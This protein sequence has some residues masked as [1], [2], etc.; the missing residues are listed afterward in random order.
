MYRPNG[1][2]AR[3]HKQTTHS[4]TYY[5]ASF[6]EFILLCQDL[7]KTFDI[8]YTEAPGHRLNSVQLKIRVGTDS[9]T[10]PYARE[11][12]EPTRLV[13]RES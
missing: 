11:H 10:H 7:C 1:V 4:P 5:M 8:S 2:D 9:I 12:N 6:A 13:T 3:Y